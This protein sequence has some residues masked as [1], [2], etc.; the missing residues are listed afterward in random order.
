MPRRPPISAPVAAPGSDAAVSENHAGRRV[1]IGVAGGSASGKTLVAQRIT[2]QLGSRKI[3]IIKQD[4]YY[5]NL[6]DL[7]IEERSRQNFDHPDAFDREL[8]AGHMRVL[9][10]GGAIR[11]PIYDFKRHLR[12]RRTK[13]VSGCQI[14]IVEGILI[15]DDPL[16]RALMDIKVYIDT[17]ADIRLLRR[18][19]R[20]VTE[21]G[22]TLDSV[23]AQYESTVRPMHM[24]FVE[25]SKRYADVIIPEGGH[26]RVGVDLL[27][28]KIRVLLADHARL[29]RRRKGAS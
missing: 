17:D 27:V 25:P 11:M 28:T 18:I 10:E 5:R 9:L 16:L 8:L 22:R 19:R 24:Q 4:S 29:A 15:L 6:E 1:L 13:L 7:P 12:T 2:E 21:R 23:I 3:A 26:N 20:D 14:I